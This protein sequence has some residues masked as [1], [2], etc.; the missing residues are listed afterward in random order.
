MVCPLL[1]SLLYSGPAVVCEWSTMAARPSMHCNHSF[2]K[3]LECERPFGRPPNPIMSVSGMLHKFVQKLSWPQLPPTLQTRVVSQKK[4]SLRLRTNLNQGSSTLS[5]TTSENP[6]DKWAQLSIEPWSYQPETGKALRCWH[7]A[8]IASLGGLG[9][10]L[11]YLQLGIISKLLLG[12]F[13]PAD[14]LV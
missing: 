6:P 12:N 10:R 8:S 13:E 11:H 9:S 14:D 5:N 4:P 2:V 1:L 7:W 3:Q